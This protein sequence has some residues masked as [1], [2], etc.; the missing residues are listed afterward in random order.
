MRYLSDFVRET[1]IPY[2]STQTVNTK[3]R[4]I[5]EDKDALSP[6][7]V[8]GS[9]RV[10]PPNHALLIAPTQR[11]HMACHDRHTHSANSKLLNPSTVI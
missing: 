7:Q 9:D 10:W 6:V 11:S 5:L 3:L 8:T 4:K 2:L 1:L